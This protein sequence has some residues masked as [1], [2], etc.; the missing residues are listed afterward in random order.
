MPV[1]VYRII[2]DDKD[3]PEQTFEVR[4]LMSEPPSPTTPIPAGRWNA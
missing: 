4:Q 3:A 2:Q 1:Y